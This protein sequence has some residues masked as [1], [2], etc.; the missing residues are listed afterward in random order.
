MSLA[1]DP[2][3]IGVRDLANPRVV[4]AMAV[5][6]FHSVMLIWPWIFGPWFIASYLGP[7]GLSIVWVP[8]AFSWWYWRKVYVPF[9]RAGKDA[10]EARLA[11]Q[12]A[13]WHAASPSSDAAAAPLCVSPSQ[14][15]AR[16]GLAIDR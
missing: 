13:R 9:E 15:A 12:R 10:Q 3:L 8:W 2:P 6:A 1:D 7:W 5:M 14:E 4:L 16:C 11:A